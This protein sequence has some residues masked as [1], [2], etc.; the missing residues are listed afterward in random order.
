ST[1]IG[2]DFELV[3]NIH[4]YC[5]KNKRNYEMRFVPEPVCWTEVPETMKV[6]SSQ[7]IRWQQGSLEVFFKHREMFLNPKYGRIGLIA[8][9]LIF[10]FDIL[11][12]LAELAGYVLLPLFYLL[13][14]LNAESCQRIADTWICCHHREFRLSPV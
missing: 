6:L 7:R 5:R 8:Y 1:T 14:A 9:P 12:P 2:E 4:K 3:M 13:G 11:G 10:I